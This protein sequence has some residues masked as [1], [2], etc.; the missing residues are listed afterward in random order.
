MTRV[1]GCG[2]GHDRRN[3]LTWAA[4]KVL[5]AAGRPMMQKE[6]EKAVARKFTDRANA[7]HRSGLPPD[8]FVAVMRGTRGIK[9]DKP[10][11][12]RW[13]GTTEENIGMT[14][15]E[16][17]ALHAIDEAGGA[18]T[19]RAIA[20]ALNISPDNLNKIERLVGASPVLDRLGRGVYGIVGRKPD[21]LVL[22]SAMDEASKNL[23]SGIRKNS[24]TTWVHLYL[25]PTTLHFRQRS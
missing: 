22:Q 17:L 20:D 24:E 14:E 2:W 1:T 18:L 6:I 4:R 9:E 23:V 5:A 10:D 16:I 25:T 8:I 15:N 19:I 3:G 13:H 21:R 7:L 12:F 11:R